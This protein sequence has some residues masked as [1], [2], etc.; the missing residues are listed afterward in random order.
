MKNKKE[1]AKAIVTMKVEVVLEDGK[2]VQL[3]E[4]EEILDCKIIEK[5]KSH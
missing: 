1:F 2:I 4:P 5:N 3:F